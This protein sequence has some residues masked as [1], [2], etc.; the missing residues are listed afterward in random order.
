MK[1]LCGVGAIAVGH[2]QATRPAWKA[3]AGLLSRRCKFRRGLGRGR[4]S[5]PS[6]HA[7]RLQN[8][9]YA[10]SDL[11]V[12]TRTVHEESIGQR[13]TDDRCGDR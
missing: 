6:R 8:S 7:P 12:P 5:T 10:G 11:L 13:T 3:V 4:G 2:Y 1:R 9:A